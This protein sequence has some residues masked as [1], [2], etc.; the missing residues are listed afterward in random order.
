MARQTK[1]TLLSTLF[2]P[3]TIL[4]ILSFIMLIIF[5]VSDQSRKI[6]LNSVASI[7]NTMRR[8][9]ER[10]DQMVTSLETVSQNVIYSNLIKE[11]FYTYVHNEVQTSP[12]SQYSD[13]QNISILYDLIMTM[14]G[15]NAPVDQINLYG[16]DTGTFS[17]GL[18]NETNYE[19]VKSRFWYPKLNHN[20]GDKYIFLDQDEDLAP[21]FSYREGRYFLSLARKYYDSPSNAPQGI[22]EVKKSMN[23]FIDMIHSTNYSYGEKLYVFSPEGNVIYPFDQNTDALKYQKAIEES[24]AASGLSKNVLNTYTDGQYLFHQI[25]SYSNFTVVAVVD[26]SN[27]MRPIYEYIRTNLFILFFVCI[28]IVGVS[29]TIS[30]R[31]S[32]PLGEMYTNVSEFKIEAKDMAPLPEIHTSILELDALYQAL[33]AMQTAAK[34][35]MNNELHLQ[36]REMQSRML[37]LQAQMNPHFLY[38]SLSTLQAMAEEGMNDEIQVMCKNIS[39]IL[40]YI[41]SDS[42]QLVSLKEEIKHTRAYLDTMQL[43]YTGQLFYDVSIPEALLDEIRLPKLCVQLIVENAIKFTTQKRSPWNISIAGHKKNTH[44]EVQIKDNGPGFS[45][46]D[47]KYLEKKISEIDQTK[48]LPNLEINGMGLMNIYIRFKLLYHGKHIFH[49]NNAVPNGAI[50]TIGGVIA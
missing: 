2:I 34:D 7:E 39:D 33:L 26:E 25:S 15:P 5:F 24:Q 38:N 17:V 48:A 3:Y 1:R 11:H 37:A 31:I 43:R 18:N 13:M 30:K 44:W 21:F 36:K 16:L 20:D 10:L 41:S 35:S 14:I 32:T 42:Q 19:S 29:Y 47:L 49:L 6:R 8:A 12:K 46:E 28:A 27:F 40:R 9:T 22:I 45:A 4:F 23:D 50:V